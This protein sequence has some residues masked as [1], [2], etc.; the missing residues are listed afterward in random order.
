MAQA[1]I[2]PATSVNGAATALATA[3]SDQMSPPSRIRGTPKNANANRFST[4]DGSVSSPGTALAGADGTERQGVAQ[5]EQ[6]A[7]AANNRGC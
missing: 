4:L 1:P 2:T 3:S 5:P 6:V 7:S